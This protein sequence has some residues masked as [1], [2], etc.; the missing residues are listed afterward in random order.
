M[1]QTVVK[2]KTRTPKRKNPDRLLTASV[3]FLLAFSLV[4]ISSASMSSH[5]SIVKDVILTAGKQFVYVIAGIVL[6]YYMIYH[7]DFKKVTK[8]ITMV[9]GALLLALLSCRLFNPVGG[10]YAWIRIPVI[11]ITIQP[12]E[13]CKAAIIM[14]VAVFTCDIRTKKAVK[15]WDLVRI[16]VVTTLV[17]VGII[18]LLQHDFGSGFALIGI[19]SICML[20][21]DNKLYKRWQ[22]GIVVIVAVIFVSTI[23]LMRPGVKNYLNSEA[24]ALFLQNHSLINKIWSK[25][26]Y[27]MY[28]FISAGDPLWDRFGYSQELL[29]SLLGIARGNIFGVG[30]GNSIQKYGYLASADADY[31]FAVIVEELGLIG[32]A[33]VFIPYFIIMFKLLRT[34]LVA[35]L[36]R[37]KVLLIG[38]FSYVFIHM[39]LNIGGISALIPL[40]GVPLILL[41]RGGASLLTVM[42]L[43]GCCQNILCKYKEKAR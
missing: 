7:F 13:F 6:Y 25:F 2:N 38:T 42:F 32:I 20:I 24:F 33:F 10:A 19:A 15:A 16:P 22:I 5:D 18:I 4:M 9:L 41:S 11:N 12:S 34:A 26:G 30:L 43:L 40:T 17:Y 23:I 27:Q 14:T 37:E 29:N 8:Y 1:T 31:I 35:K 39:F 28:R 36:E 3:L 21:P